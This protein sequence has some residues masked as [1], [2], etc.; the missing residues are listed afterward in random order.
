MGVYVPNKKMPKGCVACSYRACVPNGLHFLE[1]LEFLGNIK[2]REDRADDCPLI[3]IDL[4]R[5]G[6]CKWWN[7]IG[8]AIR[9]VDESDKPKE[10]DFCSFGERRDDE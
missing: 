10:T 1:A 4:V 9:I 5:C 7:E 2:G 8:C 3:D 6:E